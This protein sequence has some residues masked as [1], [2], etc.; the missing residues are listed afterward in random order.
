[1]QSK[2]Y[3]G[4]IASL[5]ISGM[6]HAVVTAPV[7]ALANTTITNVGL[8]RYQVD[9]TVTGNAGAVVLEGDIDDHITQISINFPNSFLQ[10]LNLAV[11]GENSLP[12][13]AAVERIQQGGNFSSKT[14]ITQFD[15]AGDLGVP[16]GV[17]DRVDVHTIQ[18]MNI[19]GDLRADVRADLGSGTRLIDNLVVDGSILGGHVRV[20][21][22]NLN[23]LTVAGDIVG[24]ASSDPSEVIATGTIGFVQAAS[25]NEVLIGD[26]NAISGNS[27]V[28]TVECSGNFFSTTPMTM[29]SLDS[30]RVDGDYDADI[31]IQQ[32]LDTTDRIRVGGSFAASGFIRLPA[33]GLQGQIIINGE[34]VAG[35]WDGTV[36]VGA[37]SLSSPNYANTS[38]SLGGGAAGEVPFDLHNEDCEPV[39][40]AVISSTA[41][42]P[43][44]ISLRHYGPIEFDVGATP[45]RME[46]QQQ[47][48]TNPANWADVTSDF[49]FAVGANPN[50]LEATPV[51]QANFLCGY[52]YRAVHNPA[53]T[54]N[55]RLRCTQIL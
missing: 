35:T 1:M 47:E 14:I 12:G 36:T 27:T 13:I 6:A 16:G 54:G 20:Q 17:T 32:P 18:S 3:V 49:T 25:M 46:R 22:G 29:V 5:M 30:L 42:K 2:L 43:S 31:T 38:G 8:N 39:D 19:G 28:G 41:A 44:V 4:V 40:G 21:G 7:S 53:P 15:I 26:S 55:D 34:D 45:I 52:R 37:T 23:S 24:D 48:C 33:S 11:R 9:I 51:S 50:I 10:I